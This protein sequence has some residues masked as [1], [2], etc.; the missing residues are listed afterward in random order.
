MKRLINLMVNGDSYSLAV[1]PNRTLIDVLRDDLGLTGT[2]KGCDMGDC[3]TC[4]VL[5]DGLAV[6]SCIV[7]AVTANGTKIETIEG[8][9]QDGEMHA[10]QKSF[11]ARGAVQCGYCTP[12]MLMASK[13]LINIQPSPS[14][15]D[16]KYALGGNLCRCTGY[17][18]ILDA[19]KNYQQH[20]GDAEPEIEN[21]DDE[22]RSVVGRSV[23]RSDVPAKVTGR[24]IYTEDLVLPNI[25][26]GRLLGSPHAHA[27]VL[28]IDT[29]KAEALPGV[30]AVITGKDVSDVLYGVS[31]ARYDE[32]VLAKDKVRFVGDEVAAVAAIDQETADAAI[33]LIEVEYEVLEAALDPFD[34]QKDGA[35]TIHEAARGKNNVNAFIDHHFGDVDRGFAEADVVLEHRFTGNFI[36]Q[37]PLEPHCSVSEWDH[38]KGN[39]TI[40]SSTQVPH[41]LQ[42][43]LSRVFEMPLGKIRVIK[44]SVGGGFGVK[45]EAMA[46]DFCSAYLSKKTGRPV[47]M[48]Y[49]REEMFYHFRGRH[50]QHM[51]M[52]IG[53]KS[54]GTITSVNFNNTLDGG[55]YTSFGIVTVYYA[56][57]MIPTLYHIPNWFLMRS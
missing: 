43:Q 19:V 42:K 35:P 39:L 46:L 5:M 51:D 15:E 6:K 55:A 27:K 10:L 20:E 30:K 28:S 29:S 23:P 37:S 25:L 21:H 52:K 57:F 26:Y 40:W 53:I 2:K 56:G 33:K 12:G 49:T 16:I 13:A 24:A 34:A 36:Y 17:T 14:D 32:Y 4:T 31:P 54:D 3:G 9:A 1:D 7:L 8:L 47:K 48:A 18:R 38:N 41:Y 11:I 44:P 45:A 22:T 50:K